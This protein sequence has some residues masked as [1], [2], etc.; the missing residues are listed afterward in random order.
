MNGMVQTCFLRPQVSCGR[1]RVG[2]A[3]LPAEVT[4]ALLG[5]SCW[6]VWW[7]CWAVGRAGV[8]PWT[9]LVWL[10]RVTPDRP[11]WTRVSKSERD[12]ET[13][14]PKVSCLGTGLLTVRSRMH[15][16]RGTVIPE[17]PFLD[18]VVRSTR[19]ELGACHGA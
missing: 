9:G 16:A 7:C 8:R 11:V 17:S 13:L 2:G 6:C 14:G 3:S 5:C 1:E 19:P 18:S 10:L 15:L 4:A 12:V